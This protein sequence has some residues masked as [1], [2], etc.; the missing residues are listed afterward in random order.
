MRILYLTWGEVPRLSSV[1]GGQAVQ[2]VSA[3]QRQE[4]VESAQLLA[5]YPIIHSGLVREKWRYK[6]Q[7][8]A[9]SERL[10]AENFTTRRIPVPPVGVHPKKWQLPSFTMGQHRF[11]AKKIRKCRA[12]V[13]QCRSYV[14]THLALETRARFGLTCRVVFDARSLM[15]E[16]GAISGRWDHNDANFAF[17]KQREANILASADLSLAVSQPMQD[18]FDKLGARRSALIHLNVDIGALDEKRIADTSRV[19]AGAPV[20][21]YCG[22]LAENTWHSPTNLWEAF[23]SFLS[24]CPGAR[25]LVITKSSHKMLRESLKAQGMAEML[26]VITF[27]SAPSP[28]ETVSLLQDADLSIFSY[29]TPANS[30]E[31][32][33]AE[34]V[35]ATKS[36]EYLCAG[37][38]MI[39]NNFCGG[40]R[41][42]AIDRDAG[43]GYDVEALL[44]AQDVETLMRQA[45]DRV[46]ISHTARADFSIDQNAKRLASLF[47]D[48]SPRTPDSMNYG[49]NAR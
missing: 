47:H 22:Y 12:D 44:S 49:D 4:T 25:L 36:A 42:Y 11:L 18:R 10:G 7:L 39:V 19:K 45:C 38:P 14:A 43:V 21:A 33:M 40:A 34:P 35:F 5:G 8:T 28:A 30:F 16:E 9:I 48:L 41:D 32:E 6:Q 46:R 23:N 13:I 24:H 1:Y 17:W 31:K 2:M 3:F 29:R 20:V 15:P 37:L 26:K 27:T